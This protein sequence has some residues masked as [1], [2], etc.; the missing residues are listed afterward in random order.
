MTLLINCCGI[1][2][3]PEPVKCGFD[4]PVV[5][6]SLIWAIVILALVILFYYYKNKKAQLKYDDAEKERQHEITL[7]NMSVQQEFFWFD[8]K[9]DLKNLKASTDEGLKNQVKD[10]KTKVSELEGKLKTEEFN[11]ELLEKQLKMYNDIFEHLKVEVRPK[12]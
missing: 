12:V 9:N 6:C 3:P 2:T 8:K 1:P 4:H 11:K 10:L 7:K 5:L